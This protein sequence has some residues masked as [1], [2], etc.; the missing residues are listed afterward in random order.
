MQSAGYIVAQSGWM[1]L[2]QAID[3]MAAWIMGQYR[4][5]QLERGVSGRLYGRFP[6]SDG[7]PLMQLEVQ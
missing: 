7:L 1:T 3:R 2:D 6:S 4:V 5:L